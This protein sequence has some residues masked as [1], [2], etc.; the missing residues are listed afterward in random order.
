MSGKPAARQGDAVAGGVIVQGSATVLIGEQGSGGGNGVAKTPCPNA[1]AVGSPVNPALGAKVLGGD[2][3]L[4]FALPGPLPAIWQRQ[5]CSHVDPTVGA[6]CG[7]LGY[8]W[9]LPT[10]MRIEVEADAC[11]FFDTSGRTIRFE[12]LAPGSTAY[13]PS[14]NIHLLRGGPLLRSSPASH[15]RWSVIPE[16]WREDESYLFATRGGEMLWVF[17]QLTAD[18]FELAHSIDRFGRRQSYERDPKL[19]LVGIVDGVGRRFRLVVEQVRNPL[20]PGNGWSVDSGRRLTGVDLILD[21]LAPELNGQALV[22]YRFDGNGDLVAVFDRHQNQVREFAYDNHRMVMHRQPGGPEHRYVYEHGAPGARVIEQHNQDGL[23]YWFSYRDSENSVLVADSLGRQ[24]VYRFQGQEGLKRLVEHVRADGSGLSYQYDAAGRLVAQ[25]DPLQ[26]VRYWQLDGEGR[27]IGRQD[28]DGGKS[29]FKWDAEGQYLVESIRPSGNTTRMAYDDYGRLTQVTTPSGA[30]TQYQYPDPAEFPLLCDLPNQIINS[31]GGK[32]QLDWSNTGQ[33]L[34]YEDCSGRTTRYQYDAQGHMLAVVDAQGAQIRYLRDAQGRL[35][36]VVL[37]DGAH[38]QY[39]YDAAGR[40]SEIVQ[41]DGQ[42][43]QLSRDTW[44]RIVTQRSGGDVLQFE[45]DIAGR[46]LAFTN[47]NQAITRYEYDS[48][49]RVLREIGVDG[50]TITDQYD[51]A[52]Q[53]V[54]RRDGNDAVFRRTIHGY[55]PV[56]RLIERRIDG[57]EHAPAER[58][59]FDFNADG[60]LMEAIVD[61]LLAAN[62]GDEPPPLFSKVSI[63]RDEHGW[64][65]GET[66]ILY[67]NNAV[68]FEH[69]IS[70]QHDAL[71]NRVTS[72]LPGLGQV[73]WLSYGSGHIHG[74]TLNQQPLVDFERNALHREIERRLANGIVERRGLDALGR[75]LEQRHL[76]GSIPATLDDRHYRY[77]IRGQLVAAQFGQHASDYRYDPRGQLIALSDESHKQSWR[78]DPAGNRLPDPV[79]G[80]TA[81]SLR[82]W[83]EHVRNN[84]DNEDFNFLEADP[85]TRSAD[86]TEVRRWVDNRIRHSAGVAYRYD[87]W[88]NRIEARYP[89]GSLSRLHYDGL[90]RLV[91]AEVRSDHPGGDATTRA[92]YRYDIFGRRLAK[93][94]FRHDGART[95]WY[96]WDTD[97]LV[98]RED[99]NAVQH[100][101]YE[102]R[103]FVPLVELKRNKQDSS[104]TRALLDSGLDAHAA[105]S[106]QTM[107]A[108]MPESMRQAF[109]DQLA[110]VATSGLPAT[111]RTTL[112]A[113][114]DFSAVDASLEKVQAKLAV[115]ARDCPVEIRYYHC[116]HLGTPVAMSNAEGQIVWRATYDPWG[117]I[118]SE[119]AAG[120]FE[121]PIRFQGQLHD[122]ET[123]L[124]YNR[125]RYY[126]PQ[127]GTYITQDPIAFG[128]DMNFYRYAFNSP[129]VH[130]DRLGL[131]GDGQ[132]AGPE[133]DPNGPLGH[134]DFYGQKEFGLDYTKE[135]HGWSSPFNPAS[136]GR[137]FQPL[138]QS[139]GEAN[140][141]IKSCNQ[142][143]FERAMHRV[144]DFY[145]HYN[146]GYRW[147]PFNSSLKCRG[148]GHACD[149][150][151]PDNDPEAWAAANEKTKDLVGKW[152]SC[153]S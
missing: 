83:G 48:L 10:E 12:P 6:S 25:A 30:T 64:P 45:Y 148:F 94:V 57:T 23:S 87:T 139:E 99:E 53:L 70:H 76:H 8:G 114:F 123:G 108:R 97:R 21:P 102:P 103:S 37:P 80:G 73:G 67:R 24:D 79:P 36:G 43:L 133:R 72:L 26:R 91:A 150:T 142:D 135:D 143:A 7:L 121:Q 3:E 62:A 46:L 78:F 15:R 128:G 119:E 116:D 2:S 115:D 55:D 107:L 58:H 42:I 38:Q 31:I 100:I 32:V 118:S 151:K 74:I 125:H 71:G 50:R 49:D 60:L 124:H 9:T 18:R 4:D 65:I 54:E 126:D 136:S 137:H 145:S 146:K 129:L 98:R 39:R 131:F 5:Y 106:M 11:R 138:E 81:A 112:P 141:A 90:H 104:A 16:R 28:P 35:T 117:R 51:A 40:L 75:L 69:T 93:T 63:S 44:G 17:H 122:P 147:D 29:T 152:R 132:S 127:L 41:P 52:G 109:D 144:Q 85:T 89:D 113:G 61:A 111:A 13:S 105:D 134:S 33:L 47:Q 153:C 101:V 95:T 130:V 149:G 88:G 22:R 77:D 59:R 82:D 68:E 27:I 92:E 56:G 140:A 34:A 86:G 20:P 66:Q 110:A 96:G 1:M 84:T 19:G 120:N 14:E